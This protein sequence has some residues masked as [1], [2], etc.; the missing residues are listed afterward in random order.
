M[1]EKL[2]DKP[3][4]DAKGIELIRRDNIEAL[5]KIQ[6]NCLRMLFETKNLSKIKEYLINQWG[7]ICANQVDIKDF[8]LAKEV[9]M[10]RYKSEASLPKGAIV[11]GRMNK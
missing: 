1:Y 11:A 4:L 10:G 2:D 3:V 7:K 9:K 5:H 6:D 8:I